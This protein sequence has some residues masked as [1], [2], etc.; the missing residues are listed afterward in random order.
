MPFAYFDDTALDE[1]EMEVEVME[2]EEEMGEGEEAVV[3]IPLV[4]T[5]FDFL[6]ES[7]PK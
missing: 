2:E 4:Y 3:I 6:V 7:L 1:E 5:L